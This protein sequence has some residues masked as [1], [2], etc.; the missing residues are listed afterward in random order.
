[1]ET[2]QSPPPP[3]YATVLPSSNMMTAIPENKLNQPQ[4][5]SPLAARFSPQ[6]SLQDHHPLSSSRSP[7][8]RN[9][10]GSIS[11]GSSPGQFSTPPGPP[12]FSSPLRPTVVPFQTS[13]A[14]PQPVAFS[15]GSTLPTYSPPKFTNGMP[16][17][18]LLHTSGV[19]ESVESPWA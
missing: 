2:S 10:G 15:S 7:G 14:S 3:G 6:R 9:N 11:S 17:L 16:Q 18:P 12:I 19:E 4:F 1:M 13:P 8:A 5:S